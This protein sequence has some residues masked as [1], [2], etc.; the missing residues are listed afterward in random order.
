M[1]VN[2]DSIEKTD[3]RYDILVLKQSNREGID[4]RKALE[5]KDWDLKVVIVKSTITGLEGACRRKEN[6]SWRLEISSGDF[7]R[8]KWEQLAMTLD[9]FSLV[10]AI[11]MAKRT[12]DESL[13]ICEGNFTYIDIKTPCTNPKSG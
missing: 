6:G 8:S 13:L 1:C 5:S 12:R 3:E 9:F 11:F 7:D 4:V 10:P 2:L